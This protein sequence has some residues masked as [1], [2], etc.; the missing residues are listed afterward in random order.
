MILQPQRILSVAHQTRWGQRRRNDQAEAKVFL[1]NRH[2]ERELR[3]KSCFFRRKLW[4]EVPYKGPNK[5]AITPL[6]AAEC[7]KLKGE[8][9]LAS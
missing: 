8:K 2:T 6:L 5:I 1:E 9:F 4:A 7:Q 3:H